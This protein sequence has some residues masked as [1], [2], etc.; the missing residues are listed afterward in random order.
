MKYTLTVRI[1]AGKREC[2]KC[3]YGRSTTSWCELFFRKHRKFQY[4]WLRLPECLEK[5]K[6]V[7]EPK[8]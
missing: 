5:A 2:G 1:E 7:K 6:L 8:P 4:G 3:H